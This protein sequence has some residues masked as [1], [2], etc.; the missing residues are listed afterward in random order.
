MKRLIVAIGFLIVISG[1]GKEKLNWEVVESQIY[2]ELELKLAHNDDFSEDNP[3]DTIPN[4]LSNIFI[5]KHEYSEGTYGL[6][7]YRKEMLIGLPNSLGDF[8]YEDEEIYDNLDCALW[9][10]YITNDDG[11]YR[12]H[13]GWIEGKYENGEWVISFHVSY[14]GKDNN[15]YEMIQNAEY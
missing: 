2:P 14:G 5:E 15:R 4:Y 12:I 9:H 11:Y 10:N 6:N 8:R 7:H 1:C 3:Y 13:K